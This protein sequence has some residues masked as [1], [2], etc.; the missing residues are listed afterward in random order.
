MRCTQCNSELSLGERFCGACGR[1]R[2]ESHSRFISVEEEFL[3]LQ[4]QK[5]GD[6][7]GED[8]F[9][10]ALRKLILTD[11]AGV[12]WMIGRESGIWHCFNGQEWI[13]A[14]LP[15]DSAENSFIGKADKPSTKT[16][17]IKSKQSRKVAA[18]HDRSEMPVSPK[19]ETKAG[20]G[21]LGKSSGVLLILAGI[22]GVMVLTGVIFRQEVV[23]KF[24]S[25]AVD[26][27]WGQVVSSPETSTDLFQPSMPAALPTEVSAPNESTS[28]SLEKGACPAAN[29]QADTPPDFIFSIEDS[30][31]GDKFGYFRDKDESSVLMMSCSLPKYG[32]SLETEIDG[33]LNAMS[34]VTWQEPEFGNSQIGPTAWAEGAFQNEDPVFAALA[35]PTRD[36][37]MI[38]FW[39]LGKKNGWD[40]TFAAFQQV[41]G[42]LEY[43]K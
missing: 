15:G 16:D 33:F 4:R 37:Y 5:Q 10:E 19:P 9:T 17:P 28:S 32:N 34:D 21:C 41:V 20:K 11:E 36:G 42:S 22:C 30:T 12:S 2:P 43:V 40:Q 14:E 27:G 35:G 18:S 3:I 13:L 7:I 1:P 38:T 29:V 31:E 23:N 26:K 39:G 24:V 8:E 6:T 25:I